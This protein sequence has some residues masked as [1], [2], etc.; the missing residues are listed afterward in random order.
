LIVPKD[1]A[2]HGHARAAVPVAAGIHAHVA[3]YTFA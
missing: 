2:R 3:V 1:R